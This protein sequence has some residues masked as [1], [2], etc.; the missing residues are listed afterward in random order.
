VKNGGV[1][2]C[3]DA[4]SGRMIFEERLSAPGG[5]Y[6]SPVAADG[7]IYTA[8]DR[9]VITVV[10]ATDRLRVLAQADLKEAIMATPALVEDAL[11]VRSAGHVWAFSEK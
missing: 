8:S 6:A 5:Y 1:L 10:E 2:F 9:G 3:R 11:Y 4:K 7:R